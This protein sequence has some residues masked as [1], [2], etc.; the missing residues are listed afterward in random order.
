MTKKVKLFFALYQDDSSEFDNKIV[1]KN[2]MVIYKSNNS[3]L[4]DELGENGYEATV[5]LT[6]DDFENIKSGSLVNEA[7]TEE[8]MEFLE[9]SFTTWSG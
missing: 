9:K 1:Y 6:P 8:E 7:I 2:H 4:L 5:V 3:Q